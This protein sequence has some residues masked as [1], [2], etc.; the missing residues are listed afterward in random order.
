MATKYTSIEPIQ[1]KEK[2]VFRS[3]IESNFK[4]TNTTASPES[5]DNV[6]H[7]GYDIFYEDVFKCW[8]E[9]INSFVLY[10]GTKGNEFD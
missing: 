5:Y 8:N 4:I 10:F 9:S 7:I 2:T 1:K 6:L 3:V